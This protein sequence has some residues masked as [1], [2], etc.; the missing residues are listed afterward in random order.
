[1]IHLDFETRSLVDLKLCGV[2]VYS[3]HPSTEILCMGYAFKD[4]DVKI[5]KPGDQ[6]PS[7]K[8]Q[9]II[10]HNAAFEIAIWKNVAVKKYGFPDV[11]A[12][13][14][15][16]TMAMCYAMA[17]PG[18]LEKAALALGVNEGK[19]MK[20]HRL[21][22][23]LSQ[24]KDEKNGEIIWWDDPLKLRRLYEYCERDVTV[25][26][27]IFH[28]L[29]RLSSYEE[30][31]WLLDRRINDRGIAIDRKCV[32]AALTIVAN[33]KVRLD[34]KMREITNG[35]VVSCTAA[36]QLG[37]WVRAQGHKVKGVAKADI[38]ALLEKNVSAHVREALLT[39][40]EAAKTSTAKLERMKNGV[41]LDGRMRGLFQ[42]HGASTGRFS[43]RQIQIQNLPRPNISQKEIEKV[44]NI[45]KEVT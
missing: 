22:L 11:K 21:M 34:H 17:L 6:V 4:E 25:E 33:E 28:R 23:M 30:K 15:I 38:T 40:Q 8:N 45:L 27:E 41:C 37:Q 16:C 24:P 12:D 20:G 2:D 14:F 7:F 1:M 13:Q 43:G 44:F 36:V 39:R 9:K 35:E 32:K 3:E 26:R 5:W 19:D 31:V 29:Q 10:S 42:Y 18:S